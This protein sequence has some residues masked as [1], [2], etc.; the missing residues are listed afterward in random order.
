MPNSRTLLHMRRSQSGTL[1]RGPRYTFTSAIE[2]KADK[3]RSGSRQRVMTHTCLSHTSRNSSVSLFFQPASAPGHVNERGGNCDRTNLRP[4]QLAYRAVVANLPS[5]PI[6]GALLVRDLHRRQRPPSM[7]ISALWLPRAFT[8]LLLD[9]R[10]LRFTRAQ[11][12][13]AR[14]QIDQLISDHVDD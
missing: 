3:K 7:E 2:G 9:L 4:H 1:C 5:I 12:S 11:R 6:A 13:Q 14:R 8:V 10:Q